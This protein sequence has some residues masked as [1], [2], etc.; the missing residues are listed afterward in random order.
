MQISINEAGVSLNLEDKIVS[1][2]RLMSKDGET[3]SLGKFIQV[4]N[5]M[6]FK[7]WDTFD[8]EVDEFCTTINIHLAD[9]TEL[10]DGETVISTQSSFKWPVDHN[11]YKSP[12][13]KK[14]EDD[15]TKKNA[16]YEYK[17]V[18]GLVASNEKRKIKGKKSRSKS[19]AAKKNRVSRSV[20]FADIDKRAEEYINT[21]DSFTIPELAKVLDISET[22]ARKRAL[23]YNPDRSKIVT[24]SKSITCHDKIQKYVDSHDIYY[25][26]DMAI[27]L[28]IAESAIRRHLKTIDP[29]NS[30]RG[31]RRFSN[32]NKEH[33]KQESI[34]D[35][36][37]LNDKDNSR[38][39]W[40]DNAITVIG[41]KVHR[42]KK[43]ILKP[44]IDELT[45]SYGIVFIQKGKD[46]LYDHKFNPIEDYP[47]PTPYEVM[48]LDEDIFSMASAQLIDKYEL[49][50]SE[51]HS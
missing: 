30:K 44:V 2:L 17:G 32:D 29:D 1:L 15:A 27:E 50:P 34:F 9:E 48:I 14:I 33:K 13:V 36:M 8:K 45:K 42:S 4:L 38:K 24:K 28:G 51:V 16:S 39:E 22:A 19:K 31:D 46:I 6:E 37:A 23:K 11:Y 10:S 41:R 49:N 40:I 21:H 20:K 26:S 25:V 12:I 43:Q 47:L 18:E 7:D 5:I 35:Y 3:V